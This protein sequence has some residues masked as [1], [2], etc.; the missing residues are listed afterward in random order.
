MTGPRGRWATIAVWAVLAAVGFVFHSHLNDVTSAGQTSFLPAHSQ[1]TRVVQLIKTGFHGGENVPLFIVFERRSGLTSAD[2]L[3]IGKIGHRLTHLRLDGATPVFDSVTTTGKE[4]LPGIGLVSP[5][6][7]AAIVALGIDA[8]HRNAV[9]HDV[10]AI[11][12]L[13]G[14]STPPVQ[15]HVTGPAGLVT[16]LQRIAAKAGTTLLVVTLVL[17]LV[18]LLAVYL[19]PLLAILPLVVVAAAYMVVSGIIYLLAHAG[20]IKIDTERTLLLL[21]LIFGTGTDYSLLLVH[22]HREALGDGAPTAEALREGVQSSAAA[23]AASGATVIAAMLVLLLA[24]LESTR[25]LGPVLA[26]GIAVM[27]L[28]SFTLMPALLSLLGER[29]FWPGRPPV[30]QSRHRSW[31]H[32]AGLVRRR[33]AP[34]TGLI[35]AVLVLAACGNL[36]PHG[37]IGFGQGQISVT[38]SS[39]GTAALDRQFPDGLTG[40]LTALVHKPAVAR[41]VKDLNALLD[42][43]AAI[44]AGVEDRGELALIGVI[45]TGDPYSADAAG[46]V[47]LVGQTLR[48]IDPDALVGGVPA[49]NLDIQRTNARDTK[50]L[51]P[52][53][54]LVVFVIL[55]VLLLALAA[56]LY[57][58]VTVVASFAAT[59]GLITLAF[60]RLFGHEGLSFNLVLISFIFL[61]AVGVD[62]NI[63]LMHRVRHDSR[64]IGTPEGTLTAL[65]ATGGVITGAGIIL[66]GTFAA[67]TLLPLEPLVQIGATVATGVLIDT[68]IVRALLVPSL[69]YLINDRAWWPAPR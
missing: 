20:V 2:R 57:L 67:L 24:D 25:W 39:L 23:I 36:L 51:V 52:A 38:D 28:A 37:K 27:L 16:D 9:S 47:R 12:K 10:V 41:S 31:T 69:T 46:R 55:C 22:R 54:L 68:F 42:V 30:G 13:L 65:T 58:I 33:A 21:V 59:L 3:A 43:R 53:V 17:V 11:R 8:A 50:V 6:R 62:Y 44:P 45:I 61:V 19:A 34:L 49:E 48:R 26:L 14:R 60:T 64:R 66:A 18:L 1:S 35:A 29:V 63:F 15:A 4:T 7:E 32:V 40:P 5:D 56:P